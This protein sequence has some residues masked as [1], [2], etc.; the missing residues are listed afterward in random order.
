M[1]TRS[2]SVRVPR[3]R[4]ALF[5]SRAGLSR[6]NDERRRAVTVAWRAFWISRVLAWTAG[7]LG[8][9][10]TDAGAARALN[11]AGADASDTL[12]GLLLSPANRWDAGFY[13]S[14]AHSGYYEPRTPAF[15]PLYPLL[16]RI[17]GEPID[18]L[19]VAGTYSFEIAGVFISLASFFVALYLLH[20]L[21]DLELGPKVADNAVMLTALFPTSF[22][23]SAI[24]TESVFLALTV[25][26]VYSA[27]RGR[28]GRAGVLGALASATRSQGLLLLLPVA[29]MLW[30]GPR[31]EREPPQQGRLRIRYRPSLRQVVPLLLIP[32]G[33]LAFMGY[34]DTTEYGAR[35]PFNAQEAW[36][37]ELRG[38]MVGVW[39]GL[40][41]AASAGW[42]VLGGTPV[43]H[44]AHGGPRSQIV[45][46][47][48]LV[49]AAI[50]VGGA[51]RRLRAAYSAYALGGLTFAISYAPSGEPLYSLPRFV[52]VLFPIFMWAALAMTRW[53]WRKLVLPV[54]AA[55]LACFS[56][57]FASGYWI[58]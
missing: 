13:L 12:S 42:D 27:R 22:F 45:N 51:L 2:N 32:L 50:G 43:N 28:W 18:G 30:Y 19:G 4:L 36:G 57:A 8:V 9:L 23:F 55:G 31:A 21:V 48:A 1:P 37:R 5:R 33:L 14:I 11:P 53:R 38:P 17:I 40:E 49:F 24:Y 20:R 7:I 54:S 26:C 16:I 10:V 34:M 35:A 15:F 3:M 46:L 6:L 25:G 39:R 29:I 52:I 56:A 47:A 44:P 41:S 58:A